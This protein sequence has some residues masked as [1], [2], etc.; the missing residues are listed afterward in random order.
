M[1]KQFYVKLVSLAAVFGCHAT[2]PQK[3]GAL[4]DI[5]KTAARE[6]NVKQDKFGNKS[7]SLIKTANKVALSFINKTQFIPW[8]CN[9]I[10]IA[11]I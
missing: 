11:T 7:I 1:F 10:L 9:F 2:L 8:D 5:Q 6:T 4:R 3:R